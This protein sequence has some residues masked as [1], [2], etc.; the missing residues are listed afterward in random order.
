MN[1]GTLNL[2]GGVGFSILGLLVGYWVIQEYIKPMMEERAL[3]KPIGDLKDKD[4]LGNIVEIIGVGKKMGNVQDMQ[5]YSLSDTMEDRIGIFSSRITVRP[6]M[7]MNM[8]KVGVIRINANM[9][10]FVDDLPMD[11]PS[12]NTFTRWKVYT[13]YKHYLPNPIMHEQKIVYVNSEATPEQIKAKSDARVRE[14]EIENNRLR[15]E[16][17]ERNKAWEVQRDLEEKR[18]ILAAAK[19]KEEE[20]ARLKAEAAEKKRVLDEAK[21][22]RVETSKDIR[23]NISIMVGVLDECLKDKTVENVGKSWLTEIRSL[24]SE[25]S[26][27]D[28]KMLTLEPDEVSFVHLSN[29]WNDYDRQRKNFL[30]LVSLA[31]KKK[32]TWERWAAE[33]RN[34]GPDDKE[35]LRR[36]DAI[37][38]AAS[39][40][41]AS[42]IR[43]KRQELEKYRTVSPNYYEMPR[44]VRV[45]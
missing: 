36:R 35:E 38:E 16:M 11:H 32:L 14:G 24:R 27:L 8:E 41:R 29:Y 45:N 15:L 30:V 33:N 21:A 4:S 25:I 17:E 9:T 31:E 12:Y 6:G 26:D 5:L 3:S 42:R 13:V 40:E 44:P 18:L 19:A 23:M 10:K 34:N 20:N 7:G 22:V 39:E 1:R 28:R 37:A 43:Q 2:I